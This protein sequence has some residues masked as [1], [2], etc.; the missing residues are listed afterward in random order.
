MTAT[1][2]L[3]LLAPPNTI[4]V[5]LATITPDAPFTAVGNDELLTGIH[6]SSPMR[7]TQKMSHQEQ[8]KIFNNYRFNIPYFRR[9]AAVMNALDHERA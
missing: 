2:L 4:R 9:F 5:T 6:L 7:K 8:M 3:T 1:A